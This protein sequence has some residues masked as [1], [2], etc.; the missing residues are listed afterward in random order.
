MQRYE[1]VRKTVA[2]DVDL[3]NQ[4]DHFARSEERDFSGALRYALR[5]GLLALE[6]PELTVEEIKDIIEAQVDYETGRVS[7]LGPKDV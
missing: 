6:N 5:I 3:V 2:M 1:M 7:E 4:I